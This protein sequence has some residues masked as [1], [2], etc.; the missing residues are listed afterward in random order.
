MERFPTH[1]TELYMATLSQMMDSQ[2]TS[3]T[4]L[5]ASEGRTNEAILYETFIDM[6][7]YVYIIYIIYH[8][9]IYIIIYIYMHICILYI[10]W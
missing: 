1:R 4:I 5:F 7:V 8:I 10:N 3:D 9:Y 6:Y 2:R